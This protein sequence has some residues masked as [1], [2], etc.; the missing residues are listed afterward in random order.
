MILRGI[1]R[2]DHGEVCSAKQEYMLNVNFINLA[3]T[4]NTVNPSVWIETTDDRRFIFEGT[5][6]DVAA[7]FEKAMPNKNVRSY[8]KPDKS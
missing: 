8:F 7:A 4:R 5:M 1:F 3:T 2:E 6:D